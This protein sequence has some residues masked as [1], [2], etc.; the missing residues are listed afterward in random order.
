MIDIERVYKESYNELIALNIPVNKAKVKVASTSRLTGSCQKTDEGYEIRIMK[1]LVEQDKIDLVKSTMVHELL[2]TCED[3]YQHDE[4]WREY[5]KIAE[6]HGHYGLYKTINMSEINNENKPTK[7][8][9]VCPCCSLSYESVHEDEGEK[10]CPWC[11]TKMNSVGFN[12]C[13]A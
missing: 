9:Y 12:I 3:T 6:E 10:K 2:H 5:V 8:L 4:K 13:G 1:K 7:R 11:H